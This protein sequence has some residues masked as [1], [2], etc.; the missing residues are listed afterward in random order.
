MKNLALILSLLA[1]S[2]SAR[3]LWFEPPNPDS[4]TRVVA[5]IQAK[6]VCPPS[7]VTVT[8]VS[9]GFAIDVTETQGC[10]PVAPPPD[11]YH[12]TVDLGVRPP[13][14]Y[15]VV[16]GYNN[17]LVAVADEKLVVSDAESNVVVQPN[18]GHAEGGDLVT[19]K[20]PGIAPQCIVA[21]CDS[22]VVMFDDKQAELVQTIDTGT[23][24]VRA[25]AHEAGVVDVNIR[26]G[27]NT[28][29]RKA[30]FDYFS[31]G[32]PAFFER[33]LFPVMVSGPGAYGSQWKTEAALHNGNSFPFVDTTG[34][35]NV[36]CMP[37]CDVRPQPGRSVIIPGS[38]AATGVVAF[39]SR[40]AMP[41]ANFSLLVR[42]VSREVTDFGTSI[43]VVRENEFYDR[44]FVIVNVPS[45]SRYRV[46]VRLYAYYGAPSLG[47]KIVT[48]SNAPQT[49][50]DTSLQLQ[51]VSSG[52]H[53][54]A[55]IGDLL[56]A[57]PQLAAKGPLRIEISAATPE[58]PAWGFV[59][60]TNNETQ[61][62]TVVSSE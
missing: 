50:V 41:N 13:G 19:V 12:V 32:D 58:K 43:P 26:T 31:P 42:D 62:V 9:A 57:Y 28:W 60:V 36:P 54:F 6:L 45:D 18:V 40:Q 8:M 33:V 17:V 27:P 48:L 14:V 35:F 37:S 51:T 53:A 15:D 39:A 22:P 11:G 52:T 10:P 44:P 5:H 25:P 20:A 24:V 3:T 7:T 23:V 49:L 30:A 34:L 56:S 55:Y 2:A 59:S 21:P 1:S 46:A 38:T 29:R 16:V 47:M 61:H 4:H